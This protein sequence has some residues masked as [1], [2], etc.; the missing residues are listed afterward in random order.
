M[1]PAGLTAGPGSRHLAGGC[2]QARGTGG[3]GEG[4]EGAGR[5]GAGGRP[6]RG[7]GRRAG[8]GNLLCV[9]GPGRAG[10]GGAR[11]GVGGSGSGG[12]CPRLGRWRLP[13]LL[14]RPEAQ[15]SGARAISAPAVCKRRLEEGP[16]ARVPGPGRGPRRLRGSL[17]TPVAVAAAA[18]QARLALSFRAAAAA[19]ALGAAAGSATRHRVP[20]V[21]LFPVP[22][23]QPLK[24][25]LR[26]DVTIAPPPRLAGPPLPPALLITVRP[27]RPCPPPG[28]ETPLQR[29]AGWLLPGAAASSSRRAPGR[30]SPQGRPLLVRPRLPGLPL[31]ALGRRPPGPLSPP[32]PLLSLSPRSWQAA[33]VSSWCSLLP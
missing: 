10:V 16:V 32:P 29:E 31:P 21:P 25:R 7:T 15:P 3:T 4:P 6:G 2:G 30:P 24:N 20:T 33:A 17:E 14:A 23:R 9:G 12:S 1:A 28:E 18:A 22:G 27:P 11:P 5:P 13:R 19:A 8:G 26:G